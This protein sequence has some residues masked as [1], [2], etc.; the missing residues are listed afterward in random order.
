MRQKA[1]HFLKAKK[2][3]TLDCVSLHTVKG[4]FCSLL[5]SNIFCNPH[6]LLS[7]SCRAYD[8][9]N[10]HP[11]FSFFNKNTVMFL[12]SSCLV[13]KA[14]FWSLQALFL[15]SSSWTAFSFSNPFCFVKILAYLFIG[16]YLL[17]CV[18]SISYFLQECNMQIVRNKQ[19]AI[20]WIAEITV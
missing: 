3:V 10:F 13:Q 16:V 6:F 15:R 9:Q 5:I 18:F 11:N 19:F 4:H 14:N 17:Y 12:L 2:E 1:P 7:A 20:V 8:P